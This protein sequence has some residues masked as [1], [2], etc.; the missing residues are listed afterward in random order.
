[1][2]ILAI[3]AVISHAASVLLG[4]ATVQQFQYW[5]AASL[6]S[7]GA[8][9]YVFA[10]GAVYKSVSLEI[11]LD[12][13][14]RPGHTAALS[15]IV[16]RKVPEIFRGRTDI[17]VSGGQVERTGAS[18]AVTAAGR[19]VAAR[20]AQM[21]SAFAIGDTGLYDFRTTKMQKKLQIRELLVP[22]S[23]SKYPPRCCRR[24]RGDVDHR[25][26]NAARSFCSVTRRNGTTKMS[27]SRPDRRVTIVIPALNEQ[28]RIAETI[29]GVLPLARDLLD[30]FEI[31]L[32]DDGSTDNTGAI[33]D[34]FTA[35]EPRILVV[36][37]AQRQGVGAGFKSAL[38]RA[39]FGAITLIPGDHAFQNQ[40]IARMF[41]AAGAAAA[42]D[43][44]WIGEIAASAGVDE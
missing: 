40:G 20:I 13:A 9:L 4:F 5:N 41:K 12:L 10:F 29:E 35:E 42:G 24:R 16:D 44:I 33:M 27:S 37:R 43:E 38:Q 22:R 2:A 19:A 18:F 36:R 11:L 17:L 30:D 15:D 6:F 3:A 7:F 31:I 25:R 14:Q 28:E 34:R 1:M 23:P 39:K 8:M 21:R 32:I 26:R